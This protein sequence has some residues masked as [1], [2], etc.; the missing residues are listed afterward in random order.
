MNKKFE[1]AKL[2]RLINT[3]GE[4]Y[5]FKRDGMNFY[6]EPETGKVIVTLKGMYHETTDRINIVATE[7]AQVQTKKK[8]Y[9]LAHLDKTKDIAQG[10]YVEING[11]RYTVNGVDDFN[12]WGVFAEISLE[13]PV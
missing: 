1:S 6:N 5:T 12:L 11:K 3:N 8:P 9:I 13:E 2:K 4:E 7:A 10:D